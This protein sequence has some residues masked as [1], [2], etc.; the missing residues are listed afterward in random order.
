M[1]PFP[2]S[3]LVIAEIL[4]SITR[5]ESTSEA[6]D[7][8]VIPYRFN[9]IIINQCEHSVEV[10]ANLTNPMTQP[11]FVEL[12]GVIEN[13]MLTITVVMNVK[14][15]KNSSIINH[16]NY[17]VFINGEWYSNRN[18]R[19]KASEVLLQTYSIPQNKIDIRRM[20]ITIRDNQNDIEYKNLPI[21]IRKELNPVDMGICTHVSKFNNVPEI[22]SWVIY[23]L[24]RGMD[25]I[26]IMIC[27]PYPELYELFDEEIQN[28]RVILVH[29]EW[30]IRIGTAFHRQ[31]QA[32]SMTTCFHR[33]RRNVKTLF[34]VDVDEY[35]HS[36]SNPFNFKPILSSL[37][38][39]GY[40]RAHVMK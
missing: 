34:F 31:Y 21:C 14:I 38:D 29:F 17:S 19:H 16:L 6:L 4:Y 3:L 9:D 18:H 7:N 11:W 20:Y 35:I 2:F 10:L 24:S 28:G 39:S 40:D 23:H 30:P 26:I 8:A 22:T 25:R 32:A 15:M 36:V 13:E 27:T 1:I 5:I 33:Y 12:S 37:I